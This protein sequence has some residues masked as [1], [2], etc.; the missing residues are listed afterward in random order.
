MLQTQVPLLL[1]K[2]MK[3]LD[4]SPHLALDGGEDDPCRRSFD[5]LRRALS[6]NEIIQ[7]DSSLELMRTT[8]GP[9]LYT[10][11]QKSYKRF[12]LNFI[13]L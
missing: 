7:D 1:R 5:S 8:W 12:L 2:V 10:V 6:Q 3:V 11:I 4:I 13:Y 9:I